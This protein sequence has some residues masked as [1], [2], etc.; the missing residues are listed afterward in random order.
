MQIMHIKKNN[1]I[2]KNFGEYYSRLTLSSS[3]SNAGFIE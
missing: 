1:A 3:M 2:I